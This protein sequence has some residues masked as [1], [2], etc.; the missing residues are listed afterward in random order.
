[1]RGSHARPAQAVVVEVIGEVA[2]E[3]ADDPG[4]SGRDVEVLVL[5]VQVLVGSRAEVLARCS[6]PVPY[7]GM[8]LADFGADVVRVDRI[9]PGFLPSRPDDP[10]GRSKRSIRADIKTPGGAPRSLPSR[11]PGAS[12]SRP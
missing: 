8:L 11:G 2:L 9:R 10:M 6:A 12:R 7:C 4:A 3:R 5:L 1:M